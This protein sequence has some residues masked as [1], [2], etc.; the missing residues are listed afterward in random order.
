MYEFIEQLHQQIDSA[1]RQ[2]DEFIIEG[3]IK[4]DADT[5]IELITELS[6][7]LEDIMEE[8]VLDEVDHK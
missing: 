1:R 2:M 8:A 5:L 7:I 3:N 6:D 4:F